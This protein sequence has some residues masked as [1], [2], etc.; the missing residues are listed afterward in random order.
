MNLWVILHKDHPHLLHIILHFF[1]CAAKA[2]TIQQFY[3]GEEG[4]NRSLDQEQ[5]GSLQ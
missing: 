1:M 5:R 2:N 4:G 3:G